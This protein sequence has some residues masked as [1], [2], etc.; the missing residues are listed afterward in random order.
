MNSPH[1]MKFAYI[2]KDKY[3]K[4]TLRNSDPVKNY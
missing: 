4:G 2:I 1:F 3:M